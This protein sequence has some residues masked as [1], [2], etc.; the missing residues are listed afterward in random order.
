[1]QAAIWRHVGIGVGKAR[2]GI[3]TGRNN[4]VMNKPEDWQSYTYESFCCVF[5]CALAGLHIMIGHHNQTL[6][7]RSAQV[8]YI[9]CS[10]GRSQAA[11]TPQNHH[12]QTAVG[13]LS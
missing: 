10:H 6:A 13:Q 8:S 11:S 2:K 3:V 4:C 9:S 12:M 1:M 7:L 5:Q